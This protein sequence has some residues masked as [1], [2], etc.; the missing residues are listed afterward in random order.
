MKCLTFFFLCLIHNLCCLN[1]VGLNSSTFSHH[2]S[3]VGGPLTPTTAQLNWQ[4]SEIMALIH[5]NMATFFENGDPGCNSNNWLQ[6]DSPSH[7]PSSFAPTALNCS[8]W[9]DS[10]DELGIT[11][12]VLTAKHGCGFYLWPTNVLL[13]NGQPYGYN[14]NSSFD[15]LKMFTDAM[16]ERGKGHGFY[17]SLTNNFYLNEFSFKV[18]DPSTLI[19]YQ[20]NITQND[21]ERIAIESL[22]ELWT[23]YGILTEAWAD[24]GS[25]IEMKSNLTDLLNRLQP[26]ALVLNGE[27][28]SRSPG[29]WSGTEGDVPPGWPNIWSTT[30]CD[31]N[32]PDP[33][34]TCEGSGCSPDDPRGTAFYAPSSTDYTLQA[35]DVWFFEPNYPLRSITELISTYHATVGANT[36]L[37]LD[38]AISRTGLLEQSHVD[39]YKT[40]GQWIRNCYGSPIAQAQ[41]PQGIYTLTI[42]LDTNGPSGVL[43][44]RIVL[45]E[46]LSVDTY[47]QCVTNYTLEVLEVGMSDWSLFGKSNA[48]LIGNKRIELNSPTP[49]TIGPAMNVTAVRFNVTK[50][51]CEPI[52]NISV[53]SPVNCNPPPPPPPPPPAS[54][55]KFIFQD[56]R[57]LVTNSSGVPCASMPY[58]LCHVFL[59]D[60]NSLSAEWDDGNN[61]IAGHYLTSLA[62]NNS[63]SNAINID[64][65][66]CAIHSVA[67]LL[68]GSSSASDIVFSNG[69]LV[70]TCGGITGLCLDS[71]DDGPPNPPCGGES[72]MPKQVQIGLCSSPGTKGWIRQEVKT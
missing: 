64:C 42:P 54:R 45:Q 13:P 7:D 33:A 14:V 24:G 41:L 65:N 47:G 50:Y 9:A 52:V 10:M 48:H 12:A 35:N 20:V 26:Q 43:M 71:G 34:H 39:L 51:L 31:I 16:N 63:Y 29:R 55:V 62:N 53:F 2:F 4:R 68:P 61:G 69:Q 32:A 67:K 6:T 25:P 56:G 3:V 38:F 49:G 30:C 1:V 58:T 17:Y 46:G 27:G 23:H 66:S 40:F 60:C 11:E 28:I 72:Y 8:Q 36:V 22:T 37:E 57:C 15:V 59:G 18:R 70:Y 44:D 21:W 5:F 19:P